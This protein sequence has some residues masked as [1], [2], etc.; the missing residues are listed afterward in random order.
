MA[1]LL[2]PPPGSRR[3]SSVPLLLV[4]SFSKVN[5]TDTGHS[6]VS[7]SWWLPDVG[8]QHVVE[9]P[10]PALTIGSFIIANSMHKD[11]SD[12]SVPERQAIAGATPP[13]TSWSTAPVFW[14]IR[15][16]KEPLEFLEVDFRCLRYL[17]CFQ[18][19]SYSERE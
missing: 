11:P 1:G 12:D 2:G 3:A 19:P 6:V 16:P 4:P 15:L 9:H 7:P 10:R 13:T 8:F 5:S 14:L 17:A 18:V